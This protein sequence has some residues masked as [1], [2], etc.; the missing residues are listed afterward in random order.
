MNRKD[1]KDGLRL[2]VHSS[3]LWLQM[4]FFVGI[5]LATSSCYEAQDGCLDLNAT[6]YDVMA[7]EFC[8]DDCCN[9]PSLNLAFRHLIVPTDFPDTTIFLRYNTFYPTFDNTLDTFTIERIRYFL[10]NIRLVRPTGEE[11]FILDSI[12]VDIDGNQVQI[13][14]S[15]AKVDRD[16]VQ[17]VSVGTIITNGLFDRIRF[18]VG[19]DTMLLKTD[20]TSVERTSQLNVSN[21]TLL[22]MDTIDVTYLSS[23]VVFNRDTFST[24]DS[25]VVQIFEKT[26]LIEV[27]F[28]EMG[29]T[30]DLAP[31]FNLSITLNVDYLKWFQGIDV[32][33]TP[34]SQVTEQLKSQIVD[35]IVSSFSIAT[36]E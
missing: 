3:Q 2:T 30:F 27:P 12:N 8:P 6:N 1:G 31:G 24:I 32:K 23:L 7:D 21:D 33:N 10:S 14:D 35:N 20:P 17:T 11:V 22:Y 34:Q 26:D 28:G 36:I 5:I 25:T 18:N 29:E 13:E 19:L 4:L 16:I 15:F 9:Y